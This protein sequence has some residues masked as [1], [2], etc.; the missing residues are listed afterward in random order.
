M[1]PKGIQIFIGLEQSEGTGYEPIG[2]FI[3]GTPEYLAALQDACERAKELNEEY[4]EADWYAFVSDE[5]GRR[6]IL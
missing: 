5:F 6:I 2:S 4:A 1:F 3:T